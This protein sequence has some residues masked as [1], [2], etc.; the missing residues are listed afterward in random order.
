[1]VYVVGNAHNMSDGVPVD[2]NNNNNKMTDRVRTENARKIHQV[3]DIS[4]NKSLK[5]FLV[6]IVTL[7]SCFYYR[8]N[9][10][11]CTLQQNYTSVDRCMQKNGT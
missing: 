9:G 3:D 11:F 1:M 10:T 4:K 2:Q 6:I 7:Q 8:K 5:L